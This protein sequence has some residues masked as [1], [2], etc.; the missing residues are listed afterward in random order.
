MTRPAAPRTLS[1]PSRTLSLALVGG[2]AAAVLSGCS[3]DGGDDTTPADALAEAKRLL[4]ET[5]GLTLQ[6]STEELPAGVDGVVDATGVGTHAPAFEGEI[7]VLVNNLSAKVPV[8]AVDGLVY[9]K[10]PFTNQFAEINPADYGAP[11]PAGFMDP[12]AGVSNWLTAA[13]EVSAGEETREGDQVVTSYEGT[14]PGEAVAS[15]IPSA[16]DQASFPV[17]FRL[18]DEGRLVAADVSGPFYGGGAEVDYTLTLSDY[19][20]EKDITR[21]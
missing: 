19:G 6:L 8:V 9:A 14:L 3:G 10:L 13:Q 15:V 2:L 17:V 11:D 18:D 4:D 12:D 5:P 20:T 7:S 16:D 21:P 1:R